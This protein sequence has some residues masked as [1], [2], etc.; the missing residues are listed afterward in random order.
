MAFLTVTRPLGPF[1]RDFAHPV[2]ALLRP[3]NLCRWKAP[4]HVNPQALTLRP[5][6]PLSSDPAVI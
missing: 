4:S 3:V 2:I 6:S 1:P 5:F